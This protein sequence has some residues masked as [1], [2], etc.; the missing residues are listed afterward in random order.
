[1]TIL[2]GYWWIIVILIMPAVLFSVYKQMKNINIKNYIDNKPTLPPHRD[3][4]AKWD[5]DED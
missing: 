3:N 4:N 2:S 1:M 5:N